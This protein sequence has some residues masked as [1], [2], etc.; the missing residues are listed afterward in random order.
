MSSCIP[1]A[2]LAPTMGMGLQEYIAILAWC[3]PPIARCCRESNCTER[4][5]DLVHFPCGLA[6]ARLISEWFNRLIVF[7]KISFMKSTNNGNLKTYS[8]DIVSNLL[9][10]HFGDIGVISVFDSNLVPIDLVLVFAL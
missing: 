7:A 8:L 9:R 6:P 4:T 5:L 2:R 1:L 3:L 10:D